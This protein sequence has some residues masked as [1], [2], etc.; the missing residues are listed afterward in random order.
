MLDARL[1]FSLNVTGSV[2][3]GRAPKE[4]PRPL[5]LAFRYVSC[6]HLAAHNDGVEQPLVNKS[7][8][9]SI[10]FASLHVNLETG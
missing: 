5:W 6:A 2:A 7:Y 4:R 1:K 3:D 9:F 10:T 8:Q